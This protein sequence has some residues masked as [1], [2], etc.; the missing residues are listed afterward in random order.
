MV[1][2]EKLS[3]FFTGFF[4]VIAIIIRAFSGLLSCWRAMVYNDRPVEILTL[5][6]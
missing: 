2:V 4:D 6:S 1:V 5:L 3:R